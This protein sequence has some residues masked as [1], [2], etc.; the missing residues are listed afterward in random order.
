MQY[1]HIDI[2]TK[3]DILLSIMYEFQFICDELLINVVQHEQEQN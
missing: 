3:D 1:S 2:Y